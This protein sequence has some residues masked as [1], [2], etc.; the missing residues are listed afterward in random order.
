MIRLS[1]QMGKPVTFQ[2]PIVHS[3]LPDG[4]RINIVFGG[5]LSRRGSNFTIRKFVNNPMSIL[6]LVESGSLSYEVAAY[7][8]LVIG[9]GMNLF[10]A[11]ET[12]SG[13]TTLLNAI[14]TFISPTGKIVSIEDT[15]EL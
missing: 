2:D 11:G 7:L 15:P 9:E 14:T 6:A 4:S 8:S 13:K 5:D 3:T 12:A 10:V 1:E